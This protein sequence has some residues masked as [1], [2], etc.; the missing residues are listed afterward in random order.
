MFVEATMPETRLPVLTGGTHAAHRISR[1]AAGLV[2]YLYVLP[3]LLC[4]LIWVYRPLL[5]TVQLSFYQWNLIPTT[6]KVAVG[7]DNYQ[8]VLTLPE[9]GSAARN[10]LLYVGGMIP[11]SIILPLAIALFVSDIQGRARSMYRVLVFAPVLV[12][13]VV[14]GIV[15]RWMLNPTQGIANQTLNGLLGTDPI[16]FLDS[17]DLALWTIVVITGWKQLGFSVLLFSASLTNINRDYIDAARLD[18]A[19]RSRVIRDIILPLLSP[20]ILFI[21]LLTVLFS[22]QWT[23]SLINVLTQGGPLDSSTN[24]YYLLWQFGFRNFNVGFSSAA[25]VILF[26]TFGLIAFVG[27]RIMDRFSFYDA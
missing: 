2:P 20:T 21:L 22:A 27:T 14:V 23:F 10:T 5:G 4:I 9:M 26:L 6:P 1:L 3:A 13:P 24:I 7:W 12:A 18:G 19:R 11:F 15:W 17:P 16:R 8:N 25:A